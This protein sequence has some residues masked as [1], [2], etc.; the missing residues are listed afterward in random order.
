MAFANRF[1]WS[2]S[3]EATFDHC[4]RRYFFHYYLS[5]G[6]WQAGAPAIAR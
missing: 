6:G 4:R 1:G 5:W 3:R 2:L